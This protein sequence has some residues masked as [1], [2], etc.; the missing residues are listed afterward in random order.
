MEK[1][2]LVFL[3]KNL[4]SNKTG[5]LKGCRK[6]FHD[7]DA[8]YVTSLMVCNDFSSDCIG[9]IGQKRKSQT[10][11]NNLIYLNNND[12]VYINNKSI[13]SDFVIQVF[14]DYASFVTTNE[15]DFESSFGKHFHVL[16]NELKKNVS[17]SNGKKS[18]WKYF[19][20]M[21][22]QLLSYFSWVNISAISVY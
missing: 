10:P 21:L 3:P 5:Y 6:S 7:C 11:H 15:I 20:L 22:I 1:N 18:F 12:I 8:F 13:H 17:V 9:F 16:R 2:I 14:Y 4:N 19:L